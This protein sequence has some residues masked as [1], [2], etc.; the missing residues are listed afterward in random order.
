MF[1]VFLLLLTLVGPSILYIFGLFSTPVGLAG[2]SRLSDSGGCIV[3][4]LVGFKEH[5]RFPVAGERQMPHLL[6][7]DTG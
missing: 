2:S 3:G 5:L 1:S 7:S 6:A 4:N